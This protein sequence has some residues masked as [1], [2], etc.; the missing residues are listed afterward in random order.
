MDIKIEIN[1]FKNNNKLRTNRNVLIKIK[2]I[3][4][5]YPSVKSE[6]IAHKDKKKNLYFTYYTTQNFH[7][8]YLHILLK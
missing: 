4:Q 8:L 5:L 6:L 1:N 2:S 7:N 3:D